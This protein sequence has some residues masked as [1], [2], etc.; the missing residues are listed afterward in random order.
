MFKYNRDYT[1]WGIAPSHGDRGSANLQW[2]YGS[3]E[4]GG[5]APSGVQGQ[6]PWSAESNFKINF[7]SNIAL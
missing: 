4:Y 6:I 3:Y 1:V 5:Y 2:G 7:M